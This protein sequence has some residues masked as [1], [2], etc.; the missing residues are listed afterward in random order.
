MQYA[1]LMCN[2]ESPVLDELVTKARSVSLKDNTKKSLEK[3]RYFEG[4]V[5]LVFRNRKKLY[6]SQV[7]KFNEPEIS[8]T[9]EERIEYVKLLPFKWNDL[10][11]DFYNEWMIVSTGLPKKERHFSEA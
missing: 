8:E 7:K 2:K 4:T 9:A 11:T 10:F 1:I 3:K 6:L 5:D